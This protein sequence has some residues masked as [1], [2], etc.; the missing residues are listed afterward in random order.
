MPEGAE[1]PLAILGGT[2]D[3]VHFGHLRLAE[4]ACL[5]LGLEELVWFPAGRPPHRQPPHA[6]AAHRL[7]MVR[8]AIAGNPRFSVDPHETA[9]EAP[10]YTVTTL[11]RLR[12]QWG[13]RRP[14]IV[15]LGADAFAGL[16]SWHRHQDILRLAHVAVATRPGH[17]L[18]PDPGWLRAAGNGRFSSDSGALKGSPAGRIMAFAITALDISATAIRQALASGA[19]ARYLLP[20]PVLDYIARH[21]L[22]HS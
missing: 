6:S 4:E 15:V 1:V 10:S 19:S 13:A 21:R 7:S 12:Q 20:D 2:F 8:L 22:Y 16:D 11:L 9:S 18:D 17:A 14:L 3:P 5:A